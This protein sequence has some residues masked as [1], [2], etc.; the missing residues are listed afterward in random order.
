[1]LRWNILP[2]V[3]IVIFLIPDYKNLYGY[4]TNDAIDDTGAI[5]KTQITF[6]MWFLTHTI[7]NV[8]RYFVCVL[9]HHAILKTDV[10]KYYFTSIGSLVSI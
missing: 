1:V 7:F 5:L 3:I 8:C 4:E 9:C 2:L 6:S 10:I